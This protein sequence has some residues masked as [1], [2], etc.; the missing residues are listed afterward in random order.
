[1]TISNCSGFNGVYQGLGIQI[2]WY[3]RE[4]GRALGAEKGGSGRILQLWHLPESVN[5]CLILPIR[6]LKGPDLLQRV[7]F[8]R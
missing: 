1:M 5:G 8:D 3:T 6:G 7:N 4:D 2:D